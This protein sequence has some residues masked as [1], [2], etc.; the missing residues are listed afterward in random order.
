MQRPIL[1]WLSLFFVSVPLFANDIGSADDALAQGDY[2]R[3]VK[4]FEALS[5]AG[6][7]T[8]MVRLASLYQRGEGV[9]R[10]IDKA[11]RF[12]RSAAELGDAEAQFNLGNMYLLGEG[13]PRDEDWALTFYR[14]A[15][16]QGHVL[17]EQNMLELYRANGID[18]AVLEP[19]PSGEDAEVIE[20]AQ[21]EITIAAPAA[22]EL[23]PVSQAEDSIAELDMPDPVPAE[24]PMITLEAVEVPIEKPFDSPS[25]DEVEALR[26]AQEH[27]IEI[28]HGE[29]AG[30]TPPAAIEAA[31]PTV[32]IVEESSLQQEY[33]ERLEG[34]KRALALENFKHGIGRLT[35]LAEDGYGEAAL[36]LADMA[37]RGEGMPADEGLAMMWRQRAAALGSAEAQY[38]LAERY[39]RGDGLDPDDAMAITYYRDAARGGHPLAQEKLRLIYADAGLPMPD[40]TRPREPVAIYSAAPPARKSTVNPSSR[41]DSDGV[42]DE[43][44]E[45]VKSDAAAPESASPPDGVGR[46]PVVSAEVTAEDSRPEAHTVELF[47]P[48]KR[49]SKPDLV[50]E[51]SSPAAPDEPALRVVSPGVIVTHPPAHAPLVSD[52]LVVLEPP[53][54]ENHE[55]VPG[56][57]LTIAH[58]PVGE[59]TPAPSEIADSIEVETIVQVDG[60]A[61]NGP[62]TSDVDPLTEINVAESIEVETIVQADDRTPSGS[63]TPDVDPLTQTDVAVSVPTLGEPVA[64][65]QTV[66]VA[67]SSSVPVAP[68]GSNARGPKGMFGRIKG[69]FSRDTDR[70]ASADP[71]LDG[72]STLVH[73]GP[74]PSGNSRSAD[75]AP[76]MDDK[77]NFDPDT[78]V[79]LTTIDDG[80][81]ALAEGRL[82]NAAELFARLAE[83]GN[84]DAQAH[85]GYMYYKGEGVE[86]NLATALDWYRRAAVQGNRDAQYNLAVA[87]AFGEGVAQDDAEA[88]TWYRRAA[89]QGSAIAQYSLGVS[90]ALG[91][92]VARDD[93]EAI[94]WY[95]AAAEQGYAAAQYNLGYSYRSGHGI[96]SD[97]GEAIKWFEAAARNGHA[98]AQYSLGYMYRSGRGVSRDLDEAI[99]WYRLAAAQ[100]HPDARAD[101]VSLNPGG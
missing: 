48:V 17:A 78:A 83:Q 5:G 55:V 77:G 81:R 10:D 11:A 56:S 36:L 99:K 20:A 92:G 12:Y 27:G 60:T 53:K 70:V 96:E 40:F 29:R 28:E 22:G 74:V 98:S 4:I 68:G 19:R 52:S 101:L 95:R 61:P 8:A 57:I 80:K 64:G 75:T 45:P 31:S 54:P 69:F 65:A 62:L 63:L 87:Y 79:S 42:V 18:S 38:Q 72:A 39:L 91:E 35:R 86:S 93:S 71:A 37:E 1:I 100:G 23:P 90:Y 82:A 41:R 50:I 76:E 89:E 7:S 6:N 2:V 15:A 44:D 94:K 16:A 32:T 24:A 84:A 97:D 51:S 49:L 14:R 26:L 30:P 21:I 46:V 59:Q 9:D 3:A 33:S 67:T 85:L 66:E 13:L 73:I 58:G 34:A 43:R 47:Q 25:V 88:V